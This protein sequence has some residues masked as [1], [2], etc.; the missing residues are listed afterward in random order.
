M[1]AAMRRK[2]LS[3]L[4]MRSTRLRPKASGLHLCPLFNFGKPL[5]EIERLANRL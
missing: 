1:R 5:L 2:P 4:N 3:R